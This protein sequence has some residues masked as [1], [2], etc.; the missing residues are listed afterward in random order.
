[1]LW[2]TFYVAGK[3]ND[4]QG[5]TRETGHN[6]MEFSDHFSEESGAAKVTIG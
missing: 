4:N 3:I 6:Y 2:S 1:M 5:K